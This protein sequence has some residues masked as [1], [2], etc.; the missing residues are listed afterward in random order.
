MQISPSGR[1]VFYAQWVEASAA[2]A[3]WVFLLAALAW[4]VQLITSITG[5]RRGR[6]ATTA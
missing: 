5:A 2:I 6:A 4:L 1:F 3:V